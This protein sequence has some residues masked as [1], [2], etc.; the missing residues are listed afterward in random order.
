MT[1]LLRILAGILIT[2][3]AASA[4]LRT[5][6]AQ[7]NINPAPGTPLAGYYSVRP[8]GEVLDDIHAK[9][10]VFEAGGTKAAVV[11]ADLI[12]MP[13]HVV[14][15]T[16]ELIAKET[17]I[18]GAN[19]LIA[20]T[21]THT[22][23]VIARDMAR[24]DFDGSS[25][26]LGRAYTEK[27][28]AL[29]AQSVADANTALAPVRLQAAKGRAE[30]LAFNRRFWM[31][32]GTVAWNPRKLDPNIVRPA[33]PVDPEVGLLTF[34][35]PAPMEKW[36]PLAT[37]V[38]YA[39]HPDTTGGVR[40]SADY[41]GALAR[42]LAPVRGGVTVFGNGTCGNLNHRNMAWAAQPGGPAETERLARILAGSVCEAIP[43]LADV[44]VENIRVRTET[45][46]LALPEI[47]EADRSQAREIVRKL[48]DTK[49]IDQVRAFQILDVI[50]REGQPWEVEVQVIAIGT[51]V[52]FVSLPGEIFVELGLDIKKRSPFPH[53]HLIELA[54]GA[55]GYIPNR[56]AYAE[57]AR[58]AAG[59]G[60]LLVEAAVKMLRE[61]KP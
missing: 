14:V 11:I 60:E 44:A 34:D 58:C 52:A 9:A 5:G 13:R 23:P 8:G 19:V 27:L 38:N 46:R 10:L 7:V 54:N 20:A 18:P 26:D 25:S 47:T 61:L 41:P 57:G 37:F 3:A 28:P 48:R 2:T 16:R 36:T 51:E 55:I 45:V 56:P 40:I 22:A 30:N 50:A 6:A 39:M 24:D 12:S 53:T 15:K 29:L 49:F 1:P 4:Q 42:A 33:G 31:K 35:A 32:D 43:R 59:S 21:H 17:G